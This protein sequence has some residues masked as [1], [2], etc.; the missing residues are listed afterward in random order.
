V[1]GACLEESVSKV[2]KNQNAEKIKA[3]LDTKGT[4]N[5]AIKEQETFEVKM[6]SVSK[7]EIKV[8]E[9][10]D[11]PAEEGEAAIVNIVN[12]ADNDAIMM[13]VTQSTTDNVEIILYNVK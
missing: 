8:E 1:D 12:V 9:T 2:D 5:E 10:A 7:E 4:N 3:S 13:Q 11:K 6:T